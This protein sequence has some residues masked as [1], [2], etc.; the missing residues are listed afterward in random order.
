M[1]LVIDHLNTLND[2]TPKIRCR[3]MNG[4]DHHLIFGIESKLFLDQHAACTS[5]TTHNDEVETVTVYKGSRPPNPQHHTFN[6]DCGC[7]GVDA[8]VPLAEKLPAN[9]KRGETV[10]EDV[11]LSALNAISR[12][13]VWRVKGFVYFA[14]GAHIL[15]WAFGRFELRKLDDSQPEMDEPVKLTVMGSRGEVKM[16]ACKLAE[17]LG[18]EVIQ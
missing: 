10:E 4:V 16:W 2:L 3:G 9:R 6:G 12:E 1:D 7:G 11:L 17:A 13:N 8:S 18:A 14:S 15:N 5:M